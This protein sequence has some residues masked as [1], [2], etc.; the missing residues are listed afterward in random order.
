[1]Q[2]LNSWLKLTKQLTKRKQISDLK[3]Q[4]IK[5]HSKLVVYLDAAFGNL[6]DGRSQSACLIFF[7]SPN[8]KFNLISW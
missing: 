3:F 7:V 1:M 6:Y 2:L 4:P 8:E 5:K